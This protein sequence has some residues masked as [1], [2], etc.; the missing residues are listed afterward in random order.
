MSGVAAYIKSVAPAQYHQYL[1]PKYDIG[2]KR[3]I[4]DPGYLESLH[5]P[6]VDME[7]DPIAR[8]VSD[9][10]ETKSGHK[11]QFDVIAFA[12][13]FDITSSVALDVTGI[14]GQRLQEYYNREGGPTGYMGTTIPGFPN[15]F[16]ILGPNTVTGH[17]SAVFAEELQM[18]YVT[19]LLRPI[20]AGDVKGFM[21]RADS[22]RSWNEMSQSKLGKGVWSGCGSWYRRGKRQEFCD[23][24][25]RKLAHVVVTA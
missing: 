8:I 22:T 12:T 11:H 9:G 17:A 10:I 3:V 21:P 1:I 16:T 13:G 14:N 6:N 19:Q 23:L 20:L 24:A 7:W 5:R 18:D 4:L 25:R 15:W 2:C